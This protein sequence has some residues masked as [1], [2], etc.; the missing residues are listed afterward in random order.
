[1]TRKAVG[2]AGA[3][4]MAVVTGAFA[5]GY[6]G[7]LIL[8]PLSLM[9]IALP[10]RRPGMIIIGLVGAA[11][12]LRGPADPLTDFARGWAL[13]VGAWFLV[14]SMV[15]GGGRFLSRG[16]T[17]IGASAGTVAG[18]AVFRPGAF[19]QLDSNVH[20]RLSTAVQPFLSTLSGMDGGDALVEVL[21]QGIE[22]EA[23]LYPAVIGVASLSALGVAWWLYRRV[24]AHDTA[25]LRPLA[26]FRFADSLVWLLIV[27]LILVL[28]PIGAV[29]ARTGSNL[30]AFMGTLYALRGLG[31]VLVLAGMPGPLGMAIGIVIGVLLYPMVAMATF[32]IGVSDIWLDIRR[33][34]AAVQPPGN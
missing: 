14:A 30:V 20:M 4:G 15:M 32:V 11:L 19:A 34:R 10:P 31:V 22:M 33:R 12:L 7:L 18:M 27:G 3:I 21:R 1:M 16:L 17:A 8:L 23:M 28:L 29:A 2:W 5:T 25:S 9:L 13:I 24:A 26:E 6:A